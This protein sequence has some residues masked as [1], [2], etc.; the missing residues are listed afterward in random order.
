MRQK[1]LVYGVELDHLCQVTEN[2]AWL[3]AIPQ[4]LND[5][6]LPWE[7]FQDNILP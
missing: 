4:R 1:E 7:E 3:T 6:E 2:G 5:M